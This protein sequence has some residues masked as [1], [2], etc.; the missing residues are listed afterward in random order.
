MDFCIL[1][2]LEVLD[3]GR[4]VALG[5]VRQR[6]LLALLVVHANEP[7]GTERLIDELWG[8]RPPT[9]ATKTVQV[10]ISRLRRALEQSR[11]QS[12][13]EMIVTRERGYELRVDPERIDARRFERLIVQ[14]RGELAA[15]RPEHAVALLEEALSLWRGPPLAE[16]AY[17]PFAQDET[18]RLDELHVGALEQLIDSKL[19]LG[20]HTEVVG[21]LEQLIRE[22]PYRERLRAQLMLAL[23]RSDR[24]AEALQAYQDGRH[25]LVEELGIEPGVRLRELERAILAQDPAL[26]L[27]ERE[28]AVPEPAEASRGLFVGRTPELSELVGALDDAISG[29]GRLALVTGEPGIGKSRLA[30][31]LV[32][33]AEARGARVLVG[34]CWEAGGAPAYWPWVQMMRSYLRGTDTEPLRRQVGT[35]GGQ[36]AM[37]LPEL[38]E[39]FRELPEPPSGEAE[40][41]RFRLFDATVSFLTS[42]ARVRPLVLVMDDLHAADEP[43]LLLLR[44]L[45]RELRQSRMLVF[46]AYRNVDPTVRDPLSAT[47]AELTREPVTRRIELVGLLESEVAEYISRAASHTPERSLVVQIHAETDG[48]PFF[49]GEV[50]RLLLREGALEAEAAAGRVR[51]PES[52]RDVVGRRLGRLSDDCRRVLVFASVIGREFPLNV[53]ARFSELSDGTLLE[54]LDEAV[55]ERLVGVVP[56]ARDHLRFAHVLI[57]DALYEDLTPARRSRLH[58]RA[59]EVLEAVYADRLESHLTEVAH[60][61]AEA[62]PAGNVKKAVS[63]ARRAGERAARLLAFEEAARLYRLALNLIQADDPAGLGQRCELLLALG[64]VQAR[65]GDMPAA[66]ETFLQAAELAGAIGSGELLA[67]AA[68]GYGGR[69]VWTGRD[70]HG[71]VPL[72][73]RAADTLGQQVSALRVRVLARLANAISQQRPDASDALSAEAL[74]LARQLEDPV[75]LAYAISARLLATRAPTNL[76][77][78]WTLTD[79][80][81]AAEDKERAFEGHG[82]RTIILAARGDIPGLRQELDAMAQLA[83]ELGQPSQRWWTAAT[84]AML[85]LLEGSFAEAEQ[86][87]ERARTLADHAVGYDAVMFNEVQRFALCR[88]HGRLSEV[89]PALEQA[90]EAERAAGADPIRPLL[91]CT[92]AVA[93]WELGRRKD[94]LCL[95]GELAADDYA[96]LH[97]NNDWLLCAALLAELATAAADRERAEALYLRLASFDG[98]NVDTDEVS[99]G[100]VSRYL[101]LLAAA[102][103][104]FEQAELHFADALAMNERIGARPWLAHT[105]EDYARAL[106]ARGDQAKRGQATKLLAAAHDTYRELG[107]NTYAERASALTLRGDNSRGSGACRAQ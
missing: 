101:G 41:A 85:A 62:A 54:V 89:L 9:T 71:I 21:E 32:A 23:Y 33:Q 84:R 24:Q 5:G 78:R 74:A 76:D 98:L 19:A 34:R 59:G 94:A 86:L 46:G 72:L 90:L 77:E 38:R 75:T 26:A 60:H 29:Q 61:F 103:E 3:D 99:T 80:L 7:L 105:Q 100:A 106:L 4:Q 35:S 14:G 58:Q 30:E 50:T 82:Y 79:E 15:Q 51:V 73:E 65:A 104:R 11:A 20:R 43:S 27:V 91:R 39:L 56:D 68:L 95:F 18:A 2:P 44:F 70:V 36:L 47:L 12:H 25:K 40:E 52:V 49:V 28:G 87:I 8:E 37:L 93:Y 48:N 45:T 81:I 107:M 53:V 17:E 42:A 63:Y 57:R 55:A 69:F 31:E 6:A 102:T 67:R 92:L 64:D 16:F 97:V 1:G 83:E 88:E 66:R 96:Q 10:N 22:H 13:P